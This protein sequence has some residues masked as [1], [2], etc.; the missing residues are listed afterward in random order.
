MMVSNLQ[1]GAQES[2]IFRA[3]TKKEVCPQNIC[4]NRIALGKILTRLFVIPCNESKL[5]SRL[6][7]FNVASYV[8]RTASTLSMFCC[9]EWSKR[10]SESPFHTYLQ[11]NS[12]LDVLSSSS[13]SASKSGWV[14][15]KPKDEKRWLTLNRGQLKLLLT[16]VRARQTRVYF[17]F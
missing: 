12:W 1:G 14:W 5:L 15:I 9:C 8:T 10:G 17:Y 3:K 2:V 11:I 4:G 6:F 7:S 16:E 13:V